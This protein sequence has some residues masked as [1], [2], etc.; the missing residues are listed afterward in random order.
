MYCAIIV[1]YYCIINSYRYVF[2]SRIVTEKPHQGSVN[3]VLYCSPV[4]GPNASL[5]RI[6]R[7]GAYPK[8]SEAIMQLQPANIVQITVQM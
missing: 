6:F 8:L 4:I 2:V 7:L 1:D 3:K 5:D